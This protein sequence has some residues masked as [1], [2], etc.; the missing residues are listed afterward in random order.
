MYMT[1]GEKIAN[2]RKEK[3]LSQLQLAE[4]LGVSRQ[5]ISKWESGTAMPGI[6]NVIVLSCFF[7]VTIDFLLKEK[8][9]EVQE[10]GVQRTE[11]KTEPVKKIMIDLWKALL[12]GIIF[13]VIGV[14]I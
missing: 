14:M 3:N 13:F 10:I 11:E 9:N 2:L 8:V 5:A 7:G 6:D 4:Q 1:V 12:L